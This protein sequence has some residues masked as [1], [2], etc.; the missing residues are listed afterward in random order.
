MAR[1]FPIKKNIIFFAFCL[2]ALAL[3]VARGYSQS[4]CINQSP[5]DL[6]LNRPANGEPPVLGL[7]YNYRSGT[8]LVIPVDRTVQY[9]GQTLHICDQ[10]Y[11][12]PVENLQGCM[13][14][15][16]GKPPDHGAPPVGQWIEFHTVY[17]LVVDSAAGCA[18]GPDRDLA[19][20][21]T[22][23]FVV[24]AFSAKVAAPQPSAPP[25]I[26]PDKGLL[27]EWIGSN[28]SPDKD[29]GGC[30]P[31]PAQW[32]FRFGCEF[33]V[34]QS[35]LEHGMHAHGAREVQPPKRGS[36]DLTIVGDPLAPSV[37]CRDVRTTPIPNNEIAQKWACP[38]TCKEP[39]NQ[40]SGK[41][42]NFPH[43]SPDPQYAVCN[44]CPLPRPQ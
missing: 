37:A 36:P 9:Q 16:V 6:T 19:C 29:P 14:E 25:V 5:R 40:F 1:F 15:K 38:A 10:H 41:W 27:A 13:D 39:L 26:Q 4:S 42:T 24:R 7:D 35:S 17:A 43:D 34:S 23:P 32:S 2:V 44:C 3:L 30:K 11:H 33:T 8:P 12:V 20:C 18:E 21:R 28:T 31:L 22:P